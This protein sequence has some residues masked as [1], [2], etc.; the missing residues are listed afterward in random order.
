[1]PTFTPDY[2]RQIGRDLFQACGASPADAALIA[3]DLVEASLMGLESHGVTRYIWYTQ[4]VLLGHIRPGAPFTIIKETPTTAV[5]DCGLDFGLVSA[6]RMVD[7][8]EQKARASGVACVLTQNCHHVGRLGTH[9]QRLAERGLVSLAFANSVKSGHFVVPFGGREGRLAPNPLAFGAPAPAGMPGGIPALVLDMSTS[10]IAEGKIRV[11]MHAGQP[12]PPGAIID[13]E[14]NPSTDPHAFYGPPR[15]YI[16]PF[17]SPDLGYKGTGLAIMVEILAGILSG[18]S[19]TADLPHINGFCL[20]AID[21]E[22]FCGRERFAA[23]IAE[24]M[25]YIASAPAAPGHERIILPGGLDYA[26]REQRLASGIPLSD[27]T[28]RLIREVA[29]QVGLTL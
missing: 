3:E 20:I 23:L 10:M 12:L 25:A 17:G 6:R 22:A 14:G 2:L 1:M 7:L 19:T 4:E 29:A 18:A 24:M 26:R 9:P 8:A 21:P 5:A 28:W 13:A 16:L 15:G 27:E 11:L